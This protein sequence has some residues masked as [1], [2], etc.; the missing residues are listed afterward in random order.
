M[1]LTIMAFQKQHHKNSKKRPKLDPFRIKISFS[2]A[3]AVLIA[4]CAFENANDLSKVSR[5]TFFKK[6]S[7]S[8][9]HASTNPLR[10]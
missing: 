10:R 9:S 2:I 7:T 1:D 8:R 3:F 4:C 6:R 5:Q